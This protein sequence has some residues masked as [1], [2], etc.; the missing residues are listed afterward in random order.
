VINLQRVNKLEML[1]TLSTEAKVVLEQSLVQI[2]HHLNRRMNASK[3]QVSLL[4]KII[5]KVYFGWDLLVQKLYSQ[6]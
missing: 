5:T 6:I 2:T 4:T 3:L 1:F